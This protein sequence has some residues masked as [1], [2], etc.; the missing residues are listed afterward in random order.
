MKTSVS[1]PGM[2]TLQS[3]FT[4]DRIMLAV[5]FI[6]TLFIF[7]GGYFTS[8]RF[9]I[10]VDSFFTILFLVEIVAKVNAYGWKE[11]WKDGWNKFDFII[12]LLAVP[13]LANLFADTDLFTHI[14]LSLRTLRVFKSIRLFK[15]IPHIENLLKGVKLAVK[16]SLIVCVAFVVM[17]FIV[18][19]ISTTLYG[20]IAPEF[21]GDPGISLFTIFRY[22][23]GDD[24][25]TFPLVIGRETP[26]LVARLTR[27]GYAILYF[28]GGVMGLSLVNSIFV[29]AMVG[30]NN[31][32]VLA[33]LEQLEKKL[34]ELNKTL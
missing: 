10:W 4:N 33:K 22:F 9:F 23:S 5:V 29:D 28:F 34:D 18:S 21:F 8:S 6:N 2:N 1:K 20:K 3:F 11:Y 27:T 13:S 12:T 17:L 15:F 24:W 32:E 19:I 26:D 25:A 30:D 31:D 14:L 7:V 16:T